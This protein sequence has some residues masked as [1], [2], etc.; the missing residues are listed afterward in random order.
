VWLSEIDGFIVTQLFQRLG[1]DMQEGNSPSYFNPHEASLVKE[2][3]QGLIP[4]VGRLLL[5]KLGKLAPE[6]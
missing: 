1:E 5:F 2:Y 6:V 4:F 3:V